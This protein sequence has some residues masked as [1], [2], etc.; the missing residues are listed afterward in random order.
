MGTDLQSSKPNMP[1]SGKADFLRR[2]RSN[3]GY[4]RLLPVF[5]VDADRLTRF[6]EFCWRHF[7]KAARDEFKGRPARR[8]LSQLKKLQAAIDNPPWLPDS[9]AKSLKD[10]GSEL[11][12]LASRTNRGRPR[13]ATA[14]GFLRNAI[15]F[16]PRAR[17]L[18]SKTNRLISQEEIDEAL[19]QIF[20]VVLRR[21]ISRASFTR[22]RLRYK[23]RA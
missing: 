3:P 8:A 19:N 10:L 6:E 7:S 14:R 21:T 11:E 9:V 1:T 18:Q 13:D 5:S 12:K 4:Q 17:N 20:P 2:L 22:M 23:I 15:L 16:I